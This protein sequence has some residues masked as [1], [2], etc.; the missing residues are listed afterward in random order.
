MSETIVSVIARE[1]ETKSDRRTNRANGKIPAVVYGKKVQPAA[2]Y[3]DE[4]ELATLLR[5]RA[6]AGGIIRLNIP[7]YGEQPVMIG[8]VQRDKVLQ[9]RILHVD[10]HQIDMNEKVKAVV[11]IDLTGEAVGVQEG[12]IPQQMS[13]T[14]EVRCLASAIP[15]AIEANV[16][17]LQ[18]GEHLYVRDLIVP[19]GIEIRSD[20]NDIVATVLAPQKE[21]PE[22]SD[23]IRDE[24]V[25]ENTAD[26]QGVLQ[27]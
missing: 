10:F 17:N 26:K 15:T 5:G 9:N 20:E 3:I 7:A 2:V 11:R 22:A 6:G 14:V 4:K 25:A 27:E 23:G 12:G 16:A 18:V 21:L 1:G 19:A 24:D 8:E 13:T